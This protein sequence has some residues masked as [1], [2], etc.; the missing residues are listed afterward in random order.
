MMSKYQ[1]TVNHASNRRL[2][3]SGAALE[4]LM[5]LQQIRLTILFVSLCL[6]VV[7]GTVDSGLER[8]AW[9]NFKQALWASGSSV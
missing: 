1:H 3:I 5:A 9:S 6:G 8:Q 7:A 2:I 4:V